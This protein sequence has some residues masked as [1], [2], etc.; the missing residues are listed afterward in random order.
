M[1]SKN[2]ILENKSDKICEERIIFKFKPYKKIKKL[3]KI[4]IIYYM[5]FW[6]KNIKL[7]FFAFKFAISIL[8]YI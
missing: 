4:K 2:V 1:F 5:S 3:K 7:N 8:D 6:Y